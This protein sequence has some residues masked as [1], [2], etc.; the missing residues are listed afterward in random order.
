MMGSNMVISLILKAINQATGPLS[1]VNAQFKKLDDTIKATNKKF[2]HLDNIGR[3]LTTLGAGMTVVGGGLAY[4]LGLTDAVQQSL[5]AEHALR[6]MGNVADL[7][8][9]Q[10]TK[11]DANL[12]KVSVRTNQY[13][14][15][16]LEGMNTLVASGLNPQIA[17]DFMLVIGKTATAA[18]AQINDISKTVFATYDNLK[19]PIN[20]LGQV[21]DTLAQSGKEGRFELRDMAQYFPMLTA[22]A[23]SLGMKGVPAVS[24]LG[25]ALQIA[26][27]GAGTPEEAARNF[28]NFI[29]KITAKDT[30]KHFADFGI[31]V[32]KELN[33]AIASGADPIEHMMKVIMKVTKGDKFKLGELFAD[34]QVTNFIVPMM[35][36]MDEYRRIRD[37][38]LKA[39]GVVDK[40]FEK[41]M[42]TTKEQLKK[43]R[44]NLSTITKE[45]SLV[46]G[47]FSLLNNVLQKLNGNSTALKV[48]LGGVG[49]L[50]GGGVL[51]SGLGITFTAMSKGITAIR[52]F[53]TVLKGLTIATKVFS[54]TLLTNPLTWW[55]IG[56]MAV[57]AAGY[58]LWKHW[59]KIIAWLKNNWKG[60]LKGFLYVSPITAPFMLLQKLV[61]QVFG[62]DL[63][64]AGR[65]IITTLLNGIKSLA[66]HPVETLK[67]IVQKMRN[68]LPF[69]PAKEGPFRDL[70]KIKLVETIAAAIKPG[71]LVSA[72]R[73]AVS[74]A[75]GVSG[76]RPGFA[77][78]GGVV[79]HYSPTIHLNGGSPAVK[80]D[81]MTVLRQHKDELLRLVEQAQAKKARVKF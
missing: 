31:D 13:Q 11:I 80:D 70:H 8:G 63:F 79:L 36:N 43:L 24:Q 65:K 72:M 17:Q 28:Q 12:L 34:M 21:M 27:K 71:P 49:A 78:A 56:I 33:K 54:L 42:G 40:D 18:T 68:L 39:T 16:L 2:E 53:T 19:V 22:G 64:Q 59:D 5:D 44:I 41:M 30:V 73:G 7:T 20:Q 9:K 48:V 75:A 81:L 29:M 77:G 57:I 1:A 35:K 37:K 52:T 51:L 25:A 38:T 47:A 74:A 60:F 26:M 3:R 50:L 58:L 46:K 62:I 14:Q 10:I 69:S 76:P 4:S 6:S 15:D 67:G 32:K 55:F 61:K 23:Q 66:M 45:S